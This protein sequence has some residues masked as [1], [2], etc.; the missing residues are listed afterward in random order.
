MHFGSNR[1]AIAIDILMVFSAVVLCICE[2]GSTRD[3]LPSFCALALFVFSFGMHCILNGMNYRYLT[4]G[5]KGGE[6]DE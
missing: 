1:Q 6:R 3:K 4:E 5:N 2:L